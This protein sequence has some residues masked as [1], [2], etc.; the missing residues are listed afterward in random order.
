MAQIRAPLGATALRARVGGEC[1]GAVIEDA[2]DQLLDLALEDYQAGRLSEAEQGCHRILARE[3]R[4]VSALHLYG[5]IAAR[6]GRTAL[7]IEFLR[8]V[9]ALEPQSVDALSDL[10]HLLKSQGQLVEAISIGE[11]AVELGPGTVAAQNNLGD[12]YLAANRL[13]AAIA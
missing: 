1:G 4:D 3:P 8:K 5:V 11:R 9:V 12:A 10:G 2:I 13:D 6:T 7:G